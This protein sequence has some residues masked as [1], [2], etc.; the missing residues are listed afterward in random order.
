MHIWFRFKATER[1]C[2]LR[3]PS[4]SAIDATAH[5]CAPLF[6]VGDLSAE[7][8][9][10]DVGGLNFRGQPASHLFAGLRFCAD[11]RC[12][13]F[14]HN[15]GKD[16]FQER[17]LQW[18][19]SPTCVSACFLA[20]MGRSEVKICLLRHAFMD[21][22]ESLTASSSGRCVRRQIRSMPVTTSGNADR[23]ENLATDVTFY[24]NNGS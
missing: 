2:W 15:F 23:L 5:R 10:A 11:Y 14:L 18:D 8:G 9:D 21:S 1:S 4:P 20:E 24:R 13:G 12:Y 19:H 6:Q 7:K 22:G 17:S 3:S 16:P